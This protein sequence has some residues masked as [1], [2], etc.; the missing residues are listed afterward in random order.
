MQR[1][2][3]GTP[4]S[5]MRK[6]VLEIFTRA[7]SERRSRSPFPVFVQSSPR[8]FFLLGSWVLPRPQ[9]LTA[10][11]IPRAVKAPEVFIYFWYE[12]NIWDLLPFPCKYRTRGPRVFADIR[13]SGFVFPPKSLPWNS[14][15]PIHVT[16][17]GV[18]TYVF[19]FAVDVPFPCAVESCS[20]TN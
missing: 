7:S 1:K 13:N 19:R 8:D 15:F 4:L 11:T 10:V 20:G 3:I 12:Y 6:A 14:L 17:V 9:S 16:A 5:L 2:F 18:E